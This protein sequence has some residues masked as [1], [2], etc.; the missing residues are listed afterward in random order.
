MTTLELYLI[1]TN[2]ILT[3]VILILLKG[4]NDIN[5]QLRAMAHFSRMA[6]LFAHT[7]S[8]KPMEDLANDFSMFLNKEMSK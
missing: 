7:L 3:G 6:V 2:V 5:K 8:D 4:A 1:A